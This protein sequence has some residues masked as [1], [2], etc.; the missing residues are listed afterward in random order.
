MMITFHT[1]RRVEFAHT[2]MAGIVHFAQFFNYMEEAEHEFLRSRGLSVVMTHAGRRIGWPRVAA[3]CD[4]YKPAFFEEVL[5]IDL[6][7]ARIGAKSLTFVTEFRKQGE[8]IAKGQ[9]TTCCCIVE[10]GQTVRSIELPAEIRQKLEA[11]PPP[12]HDREA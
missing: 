10:P 5:D 12:A 1:T 3:S 7:L 6:T 2:D 11:A 8:L 4:Y 9:I